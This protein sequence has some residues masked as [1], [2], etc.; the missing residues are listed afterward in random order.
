MRC[1]YVALEMSE[2]CRV[3][4]RGIATDTDHTN[5]TCNWRVEGEKGIL[6]IVNDRV[7][8]NGEEVHVEWEDR[9]DISDLNLPAL[10]KIVF[11]KFKKYLAE[12]CEP[13]FSGR[14]NLNSLE[15]VFGAIASSQTGQR[16]KMGQ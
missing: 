8:F 12:D 4:Y 7:Y 1:A 9:R 6:K 10:N 16:Y 3:C 2:G 15:M 11:E 5:W 13:G 14:N